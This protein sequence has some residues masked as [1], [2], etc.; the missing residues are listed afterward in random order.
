MSALSV[1]E[2]NG[3]VEL[4][5]HSEEI[6]SLSEEGKKYFGE[7]TPERRLIE[8]MEKRGKRE[9]DDGVFAGF[10]AQEKGFAIRAALENSWLE[11][12]GG[13]LV[14]CGEKESAVEA[15]LKKIGFNQVGA[16]EIDAKTL[17]ELKKRNLVEV[18]EHKIVSAKITSK[19]EVA[20]KKE[21][22]GMVS[23]LTP[24]MLKSGAWKG[25]EFR[26]YELETVVAK[27]R[28]GKKQF[29]KEFLNEIKQK[30]VG[31]GFRE[32]V[33]PLIELEFWNMDALFMAQDHPAREIHDV[34]QI[35]DPARGEILDKELRERVYAAHKFG[36][37]T[38]SRGW[39][40]EW[41]AIVASKLVLRSHTTPVSARWLAKNSKPPEKIFCL[42]KTFRPDQIDWSHFIEFNQ[43]EGIVVDESVDLRDLLGYLKEFALNIVGAKKI[44]FVPSYFPFTEP[45][46]ELHAELPGKGWIEVAGA[47]LFRPEM[48]EALGTEVPVLAWGFGIDRLAMTKLAVQDIRMLNSHD[49][50]FLENK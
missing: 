2:K 30:L 36:G 42:G 11:R 26:E 22:G 17:S 14:F 5:K 40:Y 39:N 25:K 12:E 48:L 46:I 27:T 8:A 13:K 47:G 7:G 29:Y 9:L 15:A 21:A 33:G 20:L 32:A 44:K 28:F 3:F 45:S 18:R 16:K 35:K 38:G 41:S 23:Q 6:V 43:C 19:G 4:R 49:L 10:S 31:M 34:F 24:E 50:E 1:L 37:K